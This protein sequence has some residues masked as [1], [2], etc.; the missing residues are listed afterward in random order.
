MEVNERRVY[1]RRFD[2]G[3][4]EINLVSLGCYGIQRLLQN[5]RC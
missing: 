5:T 3:Y 2:V 1:S 4:V